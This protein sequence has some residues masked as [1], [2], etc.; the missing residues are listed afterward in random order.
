MNIKHIMNNS[1]CYIK[2]TAIYFIAQWK[3]YLHPFIRH[4]A[5]VYLVYGM[6]GVGLTDFS[7]LNPVCCRQKFIESGL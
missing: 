2:N 3:V 5:D 1:F 4:C 6:L 7:S